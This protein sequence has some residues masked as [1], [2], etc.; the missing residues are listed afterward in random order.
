MLHFM[1]GNIGH[2][3]Q[4]CLIT[5]LS[6]KGSH[7]LSY[8]SDSAGIFHPAGHPIHYSARRV[9]PSEQRARAGAADR[10][11]VVRGGAFGG[12][13]SVSSGILGWFDWAALGR[14]GVGADGAAPSSSVSRGADAPN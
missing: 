7:A 12:T 8:F 4:F 2:Q 11:G 14:G 13:T 1:L 9:R 6:G 10:G 3:G 5:P